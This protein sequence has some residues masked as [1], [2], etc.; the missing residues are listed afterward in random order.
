VP[1]GVEVPQTNTPV[2]FNASL[3]QWSVMVP[4]T[5][6]E[7]TA[8]DRERQKTRARNFISKFGAKSCARGARA[9]LDHAGGGDR[10]ACLRRQLLGPRIVLSHWSVLVRCDV[11]RRRL[12]GA[13]MP[14]LVHRARPLREPL[15]ARGIAILRVMV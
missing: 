1:P 10:L 13:A 11:D 6:P 14:R 8:R 4:I 2:F 15:G 3:T 5:Q 12:L 7:R 9:L